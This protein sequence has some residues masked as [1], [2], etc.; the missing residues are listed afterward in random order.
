M[1]T[2][3]FDVLPKAERE[4]YRGQRIPAF[5]AL[6]FYG[7]A[8]LGRPHIAFGR[9]GDFTP[10]G[11]EFDKID[12][13][14]ADDLLVPWLIAQDGAALGY[15]VG[16]KHG[17]TGEDHRNQTRYFFLYVMFWITSQVLQDSTKVDPST[18]HD[19][20]AKLIR[21]QQHHLQAQADENPFRQLLAMADETVFTYMNLAKQQ[22]RYEDR[23]AFLKSAELVNESGL[24]MASGAALMR[25]DTIRRRMQ[26]IFTEHP[27]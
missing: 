15:S 22:N 2:G 3:E 26:G 14:Q 9:S 25:K 21:L 18:R 27:S 7:A 16:A 20:Y 6:R 1:Q 10:G 5:D 4:R 19:L 23:N 11:R 24:L 12:D 17:S 8:I 13:L